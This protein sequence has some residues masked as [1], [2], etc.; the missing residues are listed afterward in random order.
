MY[1]AA[2]L[3]PRPPESCWRE[4]TDAGRLLAWLP[5]IRRVQ[6]VA[7]TPEGLP[8][9]VAFEFGG[10]HTYSL[11]YQYDAATRTVAWSP[12]S[13]QRDAVRGS[14]RFDPAD[15]GTLVTYTVEDALVRPAAGRTPDDPAA[16]LEA[17]A[18]WMARTR[19]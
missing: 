1:T 2:K 6:V 8:L 9:E 14:A 10:S 19:P 4:F 17:F 11:G 18:H 7:T 13:G 16:I 5:G 12:R 3:I 15:A